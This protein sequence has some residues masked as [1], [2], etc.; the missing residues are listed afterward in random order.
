MPETTKLTVVPCTGV[1]ITACTRAEAAQEVIRLAMS[2]RAQGADVHLCNAYTL[3]LADK[4]SGLHQL[5]CDAAINFPDGMSVVWANRWRHK[6]LTL[7]KERVYGPDLFLDVL[8]LGQNFGLTHYLLGAAPDVLSDL[9]DELRA[10]FP[11]VVIVGSESPPFRDLSAS[12]LHEQRCRIQS[13]RAQLVWVGLGTPKQDWISAQ[14]AIELPTVLV[15]VGA[16]FDFVA[17]HKSQAPRWM[18]QNG[19]EWVYRLGSEPRRL[20]RRYLIGNVRFV[21]AARRES[22]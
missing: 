11:R 2:E 20:W 22:G 8:E 9:E 12:E 10:R 15:A 3:A 6:E 16:A 1:P 7:P 13:S 18:Q 19:L 14:L 5:L 4:N 21:I 17:G